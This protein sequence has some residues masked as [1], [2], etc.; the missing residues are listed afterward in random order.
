MNTG[1]LVS[2]LAIVVLGSTPVLAASAGPRF[3]GDP[4]DDTH[5]W[6]VHD[7]NRP[8]PKTVV[9]GTFS[10]ADQAGKPPSDAIVLFDGTDLA[11]WQ[12]DKGKP[13]PWRIV[14]GVMQVEPGSGGIQ[15]R[16]SFGDC[17]LHIEWAA[18]A[19]VEGDS[20]GRGNSGVFLLGQVEIQILDS[21]QNVT[22]AD[23]H[24]GAYYGVNPPMA[25]PVRPPGEFQVYDIVFRRPVYKDGKALDPGY[26]TVF[27]NGV[28]VQDHTPLEGPG[29]HMGRSRVGPLPDKG[30]ISLQ[31]HGNPMRF[32]N[33]WCRAL[34]PRV[35]EG[36]TDGALPPEIARA[37]RHEI[38]AAIRQDAATLRNPDQPLPELLRLFESLVYESDPPTLEKAEAMAT[39]Y[40]Q[41][42]KSLPAD[43]LAT[44]R[45][46]VRNLRDVFKYLA[47]F[48]RIPDAFAP[49]TAVEQLIQDQGWDR[50]RN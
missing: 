6:A 47:R 38:A 28:L 18:P 25:L 27:V 36:G 19:K 24:A 34:P 9:P 5:P 45:D 48:K 37:K 20:Q 13:A 7:G 35:C 26:V 42:V 41:T 1:N 46:E 17:Q 22:Y 50:K 12:T 43:R 31:D 23:G 32:R 14:D 4:P 44:K 15:T 8:Q 29:G 11:R 2:L 33:I 30:P 10:T 40:V 21:Y 49:K 39:A 3:Y 16:D